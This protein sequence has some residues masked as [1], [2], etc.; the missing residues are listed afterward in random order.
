MTEYTCIFFISCRICGDFAVF[1]I[2]L[3]EGR[4]I[5]NKTVLAV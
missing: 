2:V 3:C 5:K 4:I 1:D